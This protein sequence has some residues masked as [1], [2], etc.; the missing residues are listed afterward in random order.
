MVELSQL[1]PEVLEILFEFLDAKSICAVSEI[2]SKFNEICTNS[3]RLTKKL[4]LHLRYPLDLNG[5]GESI[6]SS[7]RRYRNLRIIKSRE[8]RHDVN[9]PVVTNRLFRKLGDMIH[10]IKIDW[11]NAMRPREASLFELMVRRRGAVFAR[12]RAGGHADNFDDAVAAQALANVREDIYN[13][14]VFIVRFFNNVRKMSLHNVHL[15]KGRQPN[16]PELHYPFLKEFVVKQCDSYCFELLSNCKQLD[17]LHVSDPFWNSRTPGV[18]TFEAF[19]ISQNVLKDLELKNFTYPRL[20]Q[21][22]RTASINFRLNSLVLKQVYFADKEIA[23]NFFRTQNELKVIDFQLHNEKVRCLDELL[24]YNKSLKTIVTNNTHL[25]TINIAKLRYK[26]ENCEFISNVVNP[27]VKKLSFD[28]TS[29]DKS[30]DLFKV[31]IRMFPNLETINF[32]AEES[33]ETDS[34]IC[35]DDGT[36]LE[37]VKSL[38]ISNSSVRSL[39]NV[40]AGALTSFEYVPGKTGEFIDDL[41]GGFFHRHRMIRHLVIGSP[42]E[43]SY[44]FVSYN[45]CQLIVN[46]LTHLECITIYNFGE[47][48]KSVKLLCNL[49]KLKSL[50]LSTEDYQQFTAKTKVECARNNLKLVNVSIPTSNNNAIVII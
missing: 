29:E 14:F 41:F 26:L 34:G 50:T 1:P 20:F 12:G 49:R 32:K 15:E 40:H 31:F 9:D 19:L 35:F 11:S 42:S 4:T 6:L 36:V 7:N 37:R 16:E 8:G 48:N 17:K 18:D 43:R 22:D 10:D 38:V 30:S 47:V 45:L 25:H 21:V 24:W 27:F 5:L 33:E 44:F 28:V 3:E 46:F 39:V 2:C 23:D 13:E